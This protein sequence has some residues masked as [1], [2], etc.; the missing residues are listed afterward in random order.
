MSDNKIGLI[1]PCYKPDKKLI[2]LLEKISEQT[3]LP[4]YIIFINTE[5]IFFEKTKYEIENNEKLACIKDKIVVKHINKC[6]FDHGK[7]RNMGVQIF[8]SLI[9]DYKKKYYMFMTQDA[10]PYNN[11]LTENLLKCLDDEIVMSYAKQS[12]GEDANIIEKITREFNYGAED[13]IKDKTSIDK[14]GIKTYFCSNVCS[15]YCGEVFDMLGGFDEKLILNEDMMYAHKLIN[16]GFKFIYKSDAIVVHYHNYSAIMQFRRNFDIGVSQAEN[17]D[18]FCNISSESEGFKLIKHSAVDLIGKFRFLSLLNL[19]YLSAF[20][21]LG[22]K[23]GKNYKKIPL[24]LR[25]EMAMNRDY[26]K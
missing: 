4:D 23:F 25:S 2:S 6:D 16:N 5:E 7:S 20:K 3:V 18:I 1:V 22:Y 11:L 10:I 21:Y 15:M 12:V 26:F 13:I 19:I 9:K 17:K 8:N 14:L 24:K